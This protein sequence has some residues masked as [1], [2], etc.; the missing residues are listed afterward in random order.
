MNIAHIPVRE[1]QFLQSIPGHALLPL[2][3]E[4]LQQ[5]GVLR[6]AGF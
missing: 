1:E 2:M 3:D 4:D 6:I 5:T